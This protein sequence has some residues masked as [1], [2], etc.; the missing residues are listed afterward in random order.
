MTRIPRTNH[1]NPM[2][3]YAETPKERKK[4]M[5][6]IYMQ[7]SQGLWRCPRDAKGN[8]LIGHPP[9]LLKLEYIIDF[10]QQTNVGAWLLQETWEEGNKFNVDIGGSHIF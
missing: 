7:N 5:M 8:I 6:T 4:E 2:T 9:D 1:Y 10:M 3:P